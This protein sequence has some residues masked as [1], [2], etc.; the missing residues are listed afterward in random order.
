MVAPARSLHLYTPGLIGQ[1]TSSE[2]DAV[3]VPP[4]PAIQR[5]LVRA[6][7][8][9]AAAN[10][11]S[12]QLFHS[13]RVAGRSGIA[14]LTRLA[15]TGQPGTGWWLRADPVFLRADQDRLVLFAGDALRLQAEEALGLC[16]VLNQYFQD[17]GW[18]FEAPMAERWYLNLQ[19]APD[20]Q[21]VPLDEVMGRDINMRLPRGYDGAKWRAALNEVQMLLHGNPINEARE[22][23][24]QL[25]VNSLWFWGEGPLPEDAHGS[26]TSVGSDEPLTKGLA[27]RAGQTV[28]PLP[29]DFGAW[30]S[31]ASGGDHLLVVSAL[32]YHH[33]E[34]V[35]SAWCAAVAALEQNWLAPAAQAVRRG[36]LRCVHWWPGGDWVYALDRRALRRFWRRP[37]AIPIAESTR[38]SA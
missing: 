27:L 34:G 17:R 4:V 3:R 32:Q 10:G 5:M 14:A 24:G 7:R 37:R 1:L 30:I 6:D 33:A 8:V 12:G 11:L 20:V 15:D 35:L 22:A 16:R 19:Q 25:P 38:Y 23:R 18:R 26:W 36:T 28:I 2:V 31:A 29:H 21:T 9:A 13:F